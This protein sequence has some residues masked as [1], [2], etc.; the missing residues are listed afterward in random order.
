VA[1]LMN[2]VR[3]PICLVL[4][5]LAYEAYDFKLTPVR[6]RSFRLR[7]RFLDRSALTSRQNACR[8]RTV[9]PYLPAWTFSIAY[10]NLRRLILNTSPI[11]PSRTAFEGFG[12]YA[13]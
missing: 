10:E 9:E 11:A 3:S 6:I 4:E 2:N 12:L 5:T 7:V 1:S 13:C 8:Q